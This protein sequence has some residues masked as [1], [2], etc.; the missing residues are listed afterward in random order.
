MQKGIE[1]LRNLGSFMRD[2]M[3]G[4]VTAADP[5]CRNPQLLPSLSLSALFLFS[6]SV[7]SLLPLRCFFGRD[8]PPT[9]VSPLGWRKNWVDWRT[10]AFVVSRR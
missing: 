7:A 6:F 10:G 1:E 2:V 9:I 4:Q 8:L 5:F 3:R